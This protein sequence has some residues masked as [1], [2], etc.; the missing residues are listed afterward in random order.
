M[1]HQT[2]IEFAR[3]LGIPEALQVTERYN[4]VRFGQVGLRS[5][6]LSEIDGWLST[7]ER[8]QF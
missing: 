5:E 1:P 7:V 8:N 6:E 4:Q 3:S 2:P